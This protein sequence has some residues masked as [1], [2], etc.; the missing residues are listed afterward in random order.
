M[1]KKIILTQLQAYRAENGLN[2]IH[3]IMASMF[4]PGGPDTNLIPALIRQ[5]R[6]AKKNGT[7]VIGWGTGRATRDFLYVEDAAE[8][9]IRAA[10]RY[11]KVEPIN[12]GSGRESPVA[13]IISMLCAL[14]EFSGTVRWDPTKPEGQL[15]YIMDSGRAKN[16]FGFIPQIGLEEG[17]RRTVGACREH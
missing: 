8:G 16:E 2:G 4:G 14:L 13:E 1:A 3:L 10:E 9:I 7:D 5:I 12:I 17:L 6:E 15:R 11:D